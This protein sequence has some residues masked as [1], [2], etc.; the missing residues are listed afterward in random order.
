MLLRSKTEITTAASWLIWLIA[1]LFYF[2]EYI[3]RSA[4]SVMI[5]QLSDFFRTNAAGIGFLI[6]FYYYSYAPLQLAAGTLLDRFGA[7]FV[8]PFA[9]L[10]CP[11]GCILFLSPNFYLASSGRFLIGAGS[12]FAFTGIIYIAANWIP[13]KN[14]ALAIGATQTLGMLGGI[15]GQAGV[16]M[17]LP[18]LKWQSIWE[19]LAGMGLILFI[20]LLMAIP[21]Q[22]NQLRA[23][24]RQSGGLIRNLWLTLKNPTIWLCGCLGGFIFSPTIIFVLLWGPSFFVRAYPISRLQSAVMSTIVLFGWAVGSPLMG[25]LADKLQKRK[26]ILQVCSAIILVLFLLITY[27]HILSITEIMIAM[28]LLGLFSGAQILCFAIAKDANPEFIRGSTIGTTNFLV[29]IWAAILTPLSG[30]LLNYFHKKGVMG[31]TLNEYRQALSIVII[32]LLL[33]IVLAVFLPRDNHSKNT[34]P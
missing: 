34:I 3:L 24:Q 25:L 5:P 4:P 14:H 32:C 7:Q 27:T 23:A 28:F 11:I 1:A 6:G 18:H 33:A 9:V 13:K 2:Y 29:F 12:A 10:V 16:A 17:L 19:I 8:M 21:G 20:I 22:P 26:L 15:T 31:Y 30:T